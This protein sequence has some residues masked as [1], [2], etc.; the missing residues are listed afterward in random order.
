MDYE[1]EYKEALERAKKLA[2]DLPNG[3]NDRLYHVDDLEYIF[4]VLKESEDEKVR[5]CLL[6]YFSRYQ[7]DEVFLNDIKMGDIVTWLN[8]LRWKPSEEQLLSLK[9]YIEHS[10]YYVYN[11]ELES[12]YEQ[13]KTL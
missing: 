7:Q 10:P 12:L 4:P 6:S 2:T 11:K 8:Q 3:R 9:F 13:L 1:K 5:K